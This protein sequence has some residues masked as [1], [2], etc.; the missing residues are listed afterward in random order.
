MSTSAASSMPETA[1]P[2]ACTFSRRISDCPDGRRWKAIV[3]IL[4]YHIA[5]GLVENPARVLSRQA[6]TVQQDGTIL[7]PS[8]A[9]FASDSPALRLSSAGW[10]RLPPEIMAT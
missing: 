6:A 3:T 9:S 7:T 1:G 4:R 8:L 5:Y 2:A 10:I